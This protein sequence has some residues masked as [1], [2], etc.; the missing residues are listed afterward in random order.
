MASRA[1][2][3]RRVRQLAQIRRGLELYD[4]APRPRG[5]WVDWDF[6]IDFRPMAE[7]SRKVREAFAS[8]AA[9]MRG[10]VLAAKKVARVRRESPAYPRPAPPARPAGAPGRRTRA[11]RLPRGGGR[12]SPR[13]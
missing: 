6:K 1:E 9:K 11:F 13:S 8:F 10:L 2:R 12:W 7:A 4:D 3:K 5:W